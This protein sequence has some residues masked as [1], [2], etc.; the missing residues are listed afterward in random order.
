MSSAPIVIPPTPLYGPQPDSPPLPPETFALDFAIRPAS[1][2]AGTPT[3]ALFAAGLLPGRYA[4]IYGGRAQGAVKIV[5]IDT[6]TGRVY[7][8]NA[9]R[10]DAVPLPLIMKPQPPPPEPEE[11]E[12]ESID[13]Y[14]AVDLRAQ[15]VLPPEAATNTVFLWLDEMTS[16]A[17]IVP[18]PGPEGAAPPALAGPFHPAFYF[19]RTG[20]TPQ[21]AGAEIV[22]QRAS[23]ESRVYGAAGPAFLGPPAAEGGADQLTILALD[24]RNRALKWHSFPVPDAARIARDLPFDFDLTGLFG[25]PGWMDALAPPRRGFLVACLRNAVSRVLVVEG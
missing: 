23:G 11:A 3:V 13:C 21:A 7:H 9:D 15:L 25:G 10:D 1:S 19:R 6:R 20:A 5:A 12:I 24:F 2:Q 16:P 8:N 22:L 14:F 4:Q 18:L 17:R